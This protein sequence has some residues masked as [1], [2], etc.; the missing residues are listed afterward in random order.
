[1]L[2]LVAPLVPEPESLASFRVQAYGSHVVWYL[3]VL[4]LA[5]QVTHV[6]AVQLRVLL[7][8]ILGLFLLVMVLNVTDVPVASDVAKV[9]FGAVVGTAF[10]RALDHAW[11]LGPISICVPIA[12]AWSVFSDRGVTNAVVERAQEDPTWIE[13]PTIA[14]PIAGFPYEEFGRI[15]IVDV[16]FAS[17]YLA[18]AV[19]WGMGTWRGVVALALGLVATSVLVLEGTDVAIPALPLLCLAFLVAYAAPLWRDARRSFAR[20]E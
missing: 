20:S 2:L 9:L 1:M 18:A 3:A 7:G 13:W 10:V 8:T 5:L 12:D 11:W 14:T 6:W 16:L 15:G 4:V 19:R 17:L